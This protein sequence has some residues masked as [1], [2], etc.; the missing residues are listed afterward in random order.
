MHVTFLW[1]TPFKIDYLQDCEEHGDIKRMILRN[2]LLICE[3]D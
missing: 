1:G 2:K 3:L